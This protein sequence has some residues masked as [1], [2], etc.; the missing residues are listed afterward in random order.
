MT[1]NPSEIHGVETLFEH[2][3]NDHFCGPACAVMILDAVNMRPPDQETLFNEINEFQTKDRKRGH[4]NWSS[5]P[6]GLKN[7]LNN[8]SGPNHQFKLY[9]SL[10]Q[11]NITRRLVCS[12]S[13]FKAPCIALIESGIHWI[14]VYQY[15]KH[16]SEPANCDDFLVR[17]MLGFYKRDPL[18]SV[19]SQGFIDYSIWL[20]DTQFPVEQ[21]LWTH[22]FLAICDP[23][24]NNNKKG[25]DMSSQKKKIFDGKSS[26]PVSLPSHVIPDKQDNSKVEDN[27]ITKDTSKTEDNSKDE[28]KSAKPALKLPDTKQP[29]S[30]DDNSKK[31]PIT[32]NQ[33]PGHD[34]NLISESTAR[35]YT[36][37]HLKHDGFY[38]PKKFNRMISGPKAGEP[39]LVHNLD[40]NDFWYI[41]PI[42]EKNKLISG[43]MRI[44]AKNAKLQEAVFAM[45]VDRPFPFTK[46]TDKE[47]ID[48]LRKKYGK[49]KMK[50]PISILPILVWK[51]CVQSMSKFLPFHKVRMGYT[52]LYV[53]IDGNIYSRLTQ[54]RRR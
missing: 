20:T 36:M 22:K 46:L 38:D 18:D 28:D 50:K 53:R 47:I 27:S 39:V 7:A 24:P 34:Q 31:P 29:D 19:P 44:D 42:L 54:G 52:T 16:G 4:E 41:T 8:R 1:S 45:D 33:K 26:G 5:S 6:D 23:E 11:S 48:L 14:V 2:Q 3:I 15:R 12:I 40:N 32:R 25:K 21:G 43:L 17:D 35:T 37:W 30:K 51:R 10:S 13:I 9:A 49:S